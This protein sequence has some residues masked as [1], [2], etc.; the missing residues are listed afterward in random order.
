MKQ[1]RN[2]DI[3]EVAA[4]LFC[5][6]SSIPMWLTLRS[7]PA[8]TA[9]GDCQVPPAAGTCQSFTQRTDHS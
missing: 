6:M 1:S 3:F 8:R 2:P 5:L 9:W 4:L 7:F